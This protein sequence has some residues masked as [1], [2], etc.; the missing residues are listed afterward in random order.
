MS[1]E[2]PWTCG[3]RPRER[4]GGAGPWALSEQFKGTRADDPDDVGGVGAGDA[5][6]AADA[7]VVGKLVLVG[8]NADDASDLSCVDVDVEYPC[9]RMTGT[10]RGRCLFRVSTCILVRSTFY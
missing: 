7:G 6:D 8:V 1:P 4:G 2:A 9:A 3:P 10:K 5:D